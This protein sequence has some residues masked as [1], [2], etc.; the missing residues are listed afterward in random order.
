VTVRHF[1]LRSILLL[2]HLEEC[3]TSLLAGLKRHFRFKAAEGLLSKDSLRLLEYA[4]DAALSRP[5]APL[6]MWKEVGGLGH[7]SG[8]RIG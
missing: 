1:F 3:R 4:C 7:L 5:G 2:Q 6:S 8:G